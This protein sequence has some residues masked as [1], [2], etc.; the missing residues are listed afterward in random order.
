M[1]I[2]WIQ[3]WTWLLQNR[4]KMFLTSV[5]EFKFDIFSE[6][7]TIIKIFGV[8]FHLEKGLGPR[9][10]NRHL[11]VLCVLAKCVNVVFFL[12]ALR[13]KPKREVG[14]LI[15]RS[16]LNAE[17]CQPNKPP[18]MQV[19][20]NI[21]KSIFTLPQSRNLLKQSDVWTIKTKHYALISRRDFVTFLGRLCRPLQVPWH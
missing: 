9:A 2:P 3:L 6:K 17:T 4:F 8:P 20:R 5:Q 12:I 7:I 16:E 11:Y 21:W 15:W 14:G 1:Y 18:H 10:P 19:V 13:R